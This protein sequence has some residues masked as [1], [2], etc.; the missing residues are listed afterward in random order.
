MPRGKQ[1]SSKH[2]RAAPAPEPQGPSTSAAPTKD[3]RN[4]D[5]LR[6]RT[7]GSDAARE[8]ALHRATMSVFNPY[9]NGSPDAVPEGL[10]VTEL[11]PEQP[12]FIVTVDN[13]LSADE[14]G[15]QQ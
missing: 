9:S 6:T 4:P 8:A 7:S 5:K 14:C 1:G 2:G 11:V 12:G 15:G 3:Y 10:V 13:L